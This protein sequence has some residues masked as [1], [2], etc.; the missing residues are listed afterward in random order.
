MPNL[1][2]AR[3]QGLDVD[4]YAWTAL[5]LPRR[6][7][8]AIVATLNRA[9]VEALRTPAVRE[10]IAELG[11]VAVSEER[12]TPEYLAKFVKSEIE[13]WAGPIKASGVSMD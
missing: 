3:E 9:V 11:S 6:T 5:F 1:A 10:R 7:P 12:A 2:T 13:K 8:E 4:A